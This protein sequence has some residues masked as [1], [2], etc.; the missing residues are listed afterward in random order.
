M[1]SEV[2]SFY[3][4]EVSFREISIKNY[5]IWYSLRYY[6]WEEI[7]KKYIGLDDY[8]PRK[9]NFTI[10]TFLLPVSFLTSLFRMRKADSIIIHS[11]RAKKGTDE[12]TEKFKKGNYIVID[13]N[14][15][16]ASIFKNRTIDLGVL[17]IL[18]EV[19]SRVFY[20][21]YRKKELEELCKNIKKE[22]SR[23]DFRRIRKIIYLKYFKDKFDQ[24]VFEVLLFFIRPQKAILVSS[25]NLIS[26]C[27]LMKNK[28]VQVEEVQHGIIT[29]NHVGYNNYSDVHF[30]YYPD[31]IHFKTPFWNNVKL[32]NN[33]SQRKVLESEKKKQSVNYD[34]KHLHNNDINILFLGQPSVSS[35]LISIVLDEIKSN[36]EKGVNIYYRPHPNEPI[37]DELGLEY[38]DIGSS[39]KDIKKKYDLVIG[40]YTT[41]L[42]E[43]L[44]SEL[45]VYQI[46][47]NGYQ[48]LRPILDILDVPL[49]EKDNVIADVLKSTNDKLIQ[50]NKIW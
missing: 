4:K 31:V 1:E 48:V 16:F 26:I 13:Y 6:I 47:V 34:I 9:I 15:M 10:S 35:E 50:F 38:L 22:Y 46:K 30:G 14:Y 33:F 43:L 28:S 39:I 29:K 45:A 19:L 40:V 42:I 37:P 8:Q 3:K 11:T 49:I 20:S 21:V 27:Y 17:L 23:L 32:Y 12:Y 18:K 5:R 24:F 2:Q 7:S 36:Q 44:Q 25:Y 41:M